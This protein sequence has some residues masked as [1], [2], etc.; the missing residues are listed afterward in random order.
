M[1]L[2]ILR[3]ETFSILPLLYI[4]SVKSRGVYLQIEKKRKMW[5]KLAPTWKKKH[6]STTTTTSVGLQKRVGERTLKKMRKLMAASL[7]AA[8]AIDTQHCWFI[9]M[10]FM[11][12]RK[13]SRKRKKKGWNFGRKRWNSSLRIY[14]VW[15][16]GRIKFGGSDGDYSPRSFFALL[17]RG[18][19]WFEGGGRINGSTD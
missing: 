18:F 11:Y 16:G 3:F 17:S 15:D 12:E 7:F 14:L 4:N 9:Y 19:C 5:K 8:S 1:L 6:A 13:S 10:S 2:L